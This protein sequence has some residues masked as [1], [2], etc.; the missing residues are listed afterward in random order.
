MKQL[1]NRILSAKQLAEGV[2]WERKQY[3][4]N[5]LII[6]KGDIG[7]SFFY[8]EKGVARVTGEVELENQASIKPGLCDLEVGTIFGEMCLHQSLVRMATVVALTEVELLEID[9]ERFSIYLDDNPINGYLFYKA[10][11]EVMTNRLDTANQR[12]ENIMAWG[13]KAHAIDKHL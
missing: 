11:F 7:R 2:A 6:K 1:L 13:L 3:Q 9:G 10:L 8:M 12:V 4:P 5:E